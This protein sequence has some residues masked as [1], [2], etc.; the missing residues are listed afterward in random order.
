MS[1]S[2]KSPT[3]TPGDRR[4][5]EQLAQRQAMLDRESEAQFAGLSDAKLAQRL[6]RL[7]EQRAKA[8]PARAS[9]QAIVATT[10][11]LAQ[12]EQADQMQQAIEILQGIAPGSP[13][14][15]GDAAVARL[16]GMG[17]R[18]AVER[19]MATQMLALHSAAMDCTRRA[20]IPDQP[21][22]ARREELALAAKATRAFAQLVDTLD[23]RRRGGEQ[24]VRVEHV[25]VHSGGQ[26]IVGNLATGG[27]KNAE[28]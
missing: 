18:D 16:L 4:T 28:G 12:V 21:G 19:M 15:A 25:H 27:R 26:A 2:T 11:P 5:A 8:A 3:R 14:T 10:D 23:K 24:K 1:A 17:P 13:T 6:R 22:F 20:M 7:H 9:Q